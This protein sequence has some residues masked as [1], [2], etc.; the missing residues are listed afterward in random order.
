M[1]KP[2]RISNWKVFGLLAFAAIAGIVSSAALSAPGVTTFFTS[3]GDQPFPFT[4]PPQN[5]GPG[6]IDN[7]VIG[8]GTPAVGNFTSITQAP[9]AR[10]LDL[11]SARLDVGTVPA[12]SGATGTG[13]NISRTAGTSYA[14]TGVATSSSTV[15]TK[16][17]FETSI[18]SN[19]KGGLI[20]VTVNANYTT[21]GTVTAASTNISMAAYTE[22]GGVETAITG[23]T[24]G[25]APL[26]TATPTGYTFTIPAA[27]LLVAG[28]HIVIEFTMVVVTS[29]GAATGQI[30]GVQV[31][32]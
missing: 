18:P 16:A 28:S 1:K 22:V 21:S 23:I 24:P 11:T 8:A 27:A 20:T 30:N 17:I 29:A 13:F 6:N 19:S 9:A 15:T 26:I 5:G 4:R 2:E 32:S 12:A 31:T 10:N 25:T 3:I 14:L 7:M